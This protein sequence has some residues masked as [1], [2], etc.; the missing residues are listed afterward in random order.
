MPRCLRTAVLTLLCIVPLSSA[1]AQQRPRTDSVFTVEKY[2][3]YET[4][5]DPQISPSGN[6]IVYTRRWIN[7]L[8]DR[9][10]SALWIMNADGSRNRFLTKGSNAVWSADGKRI[11]YL[12]EGEP[13][14]SQIWVRWMDTQGA[15]TQITRVAESPAS[16]RWS[17]D[18]RQV[19]FSMFTPK[20][21]TW[22][23]DMPAAPQGAKWTSGPRIVERLHYRQD[24]RGFT[25][26][27]YV[28]LFTVPAD[29]G[30]PR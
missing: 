12:A 20:P 4:V 26:P 16:L 15:S 27:G 19:G 24:R 10:D 23:I 6:E 14:G 2:F 29:G 21:A 17:P 25:E 3:D 8:E 1:A 11:A 5:A 22:K 9:W 13:K 7:K 28:H 30:T 18:G